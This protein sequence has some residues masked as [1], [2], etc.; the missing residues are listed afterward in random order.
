VE[1]IRGLTISN[2]AYLSA[3]TKKEVKIPFNEKKFNRYLNK[4]KTLELLLGK[5]RKKN[6]EESL[7]ITANIRQD[8]RYA[9]RHR[10]ALEKYHAM[11]HN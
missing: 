1:G 10:S 3:W 4:K 8:G 9:G 11:M 5:K 2:A 6:S 7:K